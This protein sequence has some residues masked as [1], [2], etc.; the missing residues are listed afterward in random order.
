MINLNKI[1][2]KK[3]AQCVSSLLFQKNNKKAEISLALFF[4]ICYNEQ[5]D[6]INEY[7]QLAQLVEHLLDVQG[8]RGSSPLLSTKKQANL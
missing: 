7:G 5:A 4:F 8:V 6:F 1:K 3:R 2:G